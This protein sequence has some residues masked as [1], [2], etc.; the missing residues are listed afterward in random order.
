M[1]LT[2]QTYRRAFLLSLLAILAFQVSAVAQ[3]K[4]NKIDSL[5]S[6]YH[7]YGQFNG[8]VLVADNG[9]VLYQK[10]F[11]PANMEWNIPNAPDTKFRLGSITKQFTATLILQLVEQGK[12][13]LDG[14]LTDYL[15]DYRKD[16]GN[17]VTIHN[18]LSHTSGIPSYTSLPGFFQNVSRNPFTVDD[19]IKKYASGELEFEPGT[20]FVYDNSGYFLLGAIIEKVTGKPYEQ[21]LKENIFDPLGMMNSGYDRWGTILNKRAT[22]YTRTPKGYQTAAYLDM[23]IPYAA[24]SLY[25]TVEDL[26]LWDQALYGDKVLTAKSK[27]LMFKPNLNNYGYGF[28]ITKAT[29]APPTKLAVPVIQHNGGINGFS[30]VIVRM[31]NEKRLIVLLDNAEDG[32]HLGDITLG[33]MS[34][35]YDQPVDNPKRSIAETVMNTIAEKDVA[36]AIAQYRELKAGKTAS[37]YNFGE[38][39]LNQLGYQLL[40]MKKVTEA[41]EIFKLN[42][43]MYPQSANAYDSLGEGYMVRGDKD[44][45]I[46]NYKK[47]FEL[48]PKNTNATAKL[49]ELTGTQKEVKVDPKILDSYAGEYEIAPTFIIKITSEDGKLM[50]QATGQ[51]KFELF[52]SSETDFYLKVVSAQVSFIKDGA[53]NVTAMTLSQNG[54]KTTGKKIK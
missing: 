19:F 42:V 13:K 50:T 27:D 48:D 7:K 24:G 6:L 31:T 1:R 36:S 16:T 34:V 47:S 5:V 37:E 49:A 2:T 41:I 4:A 29:L 12:I 15:P 25:S 53:G 30:T 28:V 26:Y 35:L 21:V 32:Q 17:K 45:S 40:Q 52:P 44:L 33:I 20:K 54:R 3:S 14:K 18:L 51:Q 38:T 22:G 8:S 23:S 39:E 9:K 10:G 46:A 43:E 11:G